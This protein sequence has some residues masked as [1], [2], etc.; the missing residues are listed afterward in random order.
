VLGSGGR[1]VTRGGPAG[2][3]DA[4][5]PHL[6]RLHL[7]AAEGGDVPDVEAGAVI[8]EESESL[9]QLGE[10]RPRPLAGQDFLELAAQLVDPAFALAKLPVPVERG[11]EEGGA[12]HERAR[13]GRHDIAVKRGVSECG[14][15]S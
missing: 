7:R 6:H 2:L 14:P 11:A 15:C 13:L 5:A 10:G 8:Q 3:G 12:A 9:P 4:V 1:T